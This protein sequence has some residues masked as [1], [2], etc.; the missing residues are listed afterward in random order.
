MLKGLTPRGLVLRC[1][2]THD[3]IIYFLPEVTEYR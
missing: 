2:L 3:I 1:S